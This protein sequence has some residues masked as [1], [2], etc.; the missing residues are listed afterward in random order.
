VFPRTGRRKQAHE[1]TAAGVA[2]WGITATGIGSSKRQKSACPAPAGSR[3]TRHRAGL[4]A[5]R[6]RFDQTR[7]S[8]AK[9]TCDYLCHLP[10]S[11]MGIVLR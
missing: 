8:N 11:E 3:L 2:R 5:Y 10:A 4:K 1:G 9:Q 7:S 6:Y